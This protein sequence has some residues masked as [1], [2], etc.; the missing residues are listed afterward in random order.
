MSTIQFVQLS[1]DQLKQELQSSFDPKFQELRELIH[2]L[3][4]ED[5]LLTR[6]EASEHLKIDLSTLWRWTKQGLI[7]S[8]GLGNRIYYKKSEI[9]AALLKING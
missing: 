7:I 8:Y 9:E 1:P 5:C 3:K 2:K 6:E 4:A